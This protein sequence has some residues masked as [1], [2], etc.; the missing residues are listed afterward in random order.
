MK[1]ER[2]SELIDLAEFFID[3]Y[4]QY[5]KGAHYLLQLA[6]RVAVKRT[7]PTKLTWILSGPAPGIQRGSPLLQAPEPH[8]VRRLRVKFHRYY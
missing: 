3:N 1:D 7:L 6:G 2:V 4:P 5:G 8:E